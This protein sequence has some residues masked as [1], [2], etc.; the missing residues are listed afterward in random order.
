MKVGLV[1]PVY[2]RPDYVRQCFDSLRK[3]TVQPRFT[4]IVDDCS[5]DADTMKLCNAMAKEKGAQLIRHTSNNGVRQSVQD[6][7]EQAIKY[8]CDIIINLDSDAVVKPDFIERLLHA[9]QNCKNIVSGFNCVTKVNPVLN[10]IDIAGQPCVLK[11]HCNGINMCFD[12]TQ[13]KKYIRPALLKEGN[14]DYN[15]SLACMAVNLPFVVTVPSVVQHIGIV[16]SM[17]H[18]HQEPDRAQD[19]KLLSLAKVTLFGIDSHDKAGIQRAAAICQRDTDFGAVKVITDDLFTRNGSA[20]QR[21]RDYSHFIMKELDKHFTTSHVLIIHADGYILNPAAWRDEW[22]QYDYIG[23][24]WSYKDNM[25]VGNG[26][27]S[28]R[29]KKLQHILATTKIEHIHPE[30]HHI[31]RTYREDLERTYGIKF[32]PEDVANKFSI[33]AYGAAVFEEGN[34][35]SGQFGFH[36]PHVNYSGSGLPESILFQKK[37]QGVNIAKNQLIR[38]T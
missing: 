20:E 3:L 6:G 19:Y 5:T 25:N 23:A 12:A 31:C 27:F 28:L 4:F 29:S 32:A 33:E 16:S 13:Y 30:D 18:N 22:L 15:V 36:G 38:R 1:I 37:P 9:K 7:I 35:Y 24:T 34:M 2:N 10:S 17:G 11:P 8:G 26:G 14:W 21:R